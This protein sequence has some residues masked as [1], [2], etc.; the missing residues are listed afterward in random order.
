M[1]SQN[2]RLHLIILALLERIFELDNVAFRQN[3]KFILLFTR[4]YL[5]SF[6]SGLISTLPNEIFAIRKTQLSKMQGDPCKIIADSPRK[7]SFPDSL[8]REKYNSVKQHYKQMIPE[9]LQS[10]LNFCGFHFIICSFSNFQIPTRTKLL[11]LTILLYFLLLVIT[12]NFSIFA[13]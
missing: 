8:R 3:V 10:L 2:F 4:Q 7:V 5:G 9:P 12:C 11:E 13:T 1:A 6:P